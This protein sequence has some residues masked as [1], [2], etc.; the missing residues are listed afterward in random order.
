MMESL[1]K[2]VQKKPHK[3]WKESLGYLFNSDDQSL[4]YLI[5]KVYIL[6]GIDEIFKATVDE[7]LAQHCSVANIR[8]G[9]LVVGVDSQAWATKLRYEGPSIVPKLRKH[10][11]LES[12]QR[13]DVY[14]KLPKTQTT[15]APPRQL[16]ISKQAAE[17]LKNQ[18]QYFED[19]TL[20][21]IFMGIAERGE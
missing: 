15:Q 18:A 5:N 21:E 14:V 11:G 8:E 12:I 3:P 1:S 10:P 4:Q 2:T 16:K 19:D 7:N 17:L 20:R 6:Q 9:C 13:I